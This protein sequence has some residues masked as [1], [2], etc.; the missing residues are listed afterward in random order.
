MELIKVCVLSGDGLNCELETSRAF[1][2]ERTKVEIVHINDFVN[3]ENSLS[4]YD[5]LALPGGFSYGDD[6]G[7]ASLLSFKI[8]RY[9]LNDME[10]FINDNKPVLGICNGFQVLLKLNAFGDLFGSFGLV[11]NKTNKF[12]HSVSRLTVLDSKCLWTQSIG[13]NISLISRHGE[14][15][16]YTSQ[17]DKVSLLNRINSSAQVVLKYCDNF[18][19]SDG[20]IAGICNENG[21]V[22]GL[23]PHPEV[24]INESHIKEKFLKEIFN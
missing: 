24:E 19:G 17:D 8:K 22:F 3:K 1:S 6:L 20:S 5:I 15:R 14:G 2:D 16:F 13:N 9:M 7:S 18:N 21:N 10:T 11:K 23:M 12:H 4:S